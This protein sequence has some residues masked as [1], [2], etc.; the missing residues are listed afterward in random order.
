GVAVMGILLAVLVALALFVPLLMAFYFAPP[1]IA[2]ANL[3]AMDA[4]KLSFAGCLRNMLPFLLFGIV[5]FVFLM[6]AAIPLGLGF[7]V[8]GPVAIAAGYCA[9][10]D[11]FVNSDDVVLSPSP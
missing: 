11:I 8:M 9:Y 4:I 10:K 7:L 6:L 2:L 5:M 3:Q 1:L